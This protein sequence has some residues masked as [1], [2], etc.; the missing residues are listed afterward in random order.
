[1]KEHQIY[2]LA[3]A[4]NASHIVQALDSTPFANFKQYWQ[5]ELLEWNNAHKGAILDKPSF[6][7]VFGQPLT[8]PCQ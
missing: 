6:F 5:A 7:Q 2:V 4:H 3:I 8:A 1:M